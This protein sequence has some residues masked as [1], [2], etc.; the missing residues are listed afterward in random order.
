MDKPKLLQN[1]LNDLYHLLRYD[2]CT[3]IDQALDIVL[4][5]LTRYVKE[6][7]IQISGRLVFTGL[8]FEKSR[9]EL[10]NN[11]LVQRFSIL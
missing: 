5:A 11:F 4:E 9:F 1:I 7:L 3:Q 2:Q 10:C 8:H 6:K